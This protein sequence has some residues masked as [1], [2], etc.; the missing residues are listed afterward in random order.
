MQS[1]CTYIGAWMHYCTAA[2]FADFSIF[3][4]RLRKYGHMSIFTI[5]KRDKMTTL[6]P[7]KIKKSSEDSL[8]KQVYQVV[9][10]LSDYIPIANDRN[11][12]GFN[13]YKYMKG[14]GDK[15]EILVKTSKIKIKGINT[16]E[17]AGRIKSELE[18]I[19]K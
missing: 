15:P 5:K 6:P 9:E 17:L 4:C 10:N 16:E 7:P 19:K 18:K 3:M 2:R 8:E 12:L 1:C 13:L 11:R 14:E